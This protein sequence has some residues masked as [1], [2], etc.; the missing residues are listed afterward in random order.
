MEQGVGA[1]LAGAR[2]RRG[3]DLDRVEADTKIRVRYLRAIE[4]EEWDALPGDAYARAF[5]RTYAGYLGLDAEQLVEEQRR[6]HG[7]PRPGE[8]LP[9]VDPRPPRRPRRDLG[10]RV[11][12]R[13]LA[14]VVS[15]ALVVVLV[16]IGLLGGGGSGG[17]RGSAGGKRAGRS[18]SGHSKAAHAPSR[19][20]QESGHTL[21]LVADAEVWVCL[22][23]DGGEALVDGRILSPG[24]AEGPFRSGSFTFSLG[25]GEVTMT[26]D[27]K[28]AQIPPTSSPVGYSVTDGRLQQLSEGER[29]TCT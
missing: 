10:V 27:G 22:L 12:P 25:N 6:R 3:L 15:V 23:G 24:A 19:R 16:A 8:K 21:R 14:A 2:G 7:A 11:S 17:D 20:S 28:Q 13:L 5:L 29:P 1:K 9:Q 4:E 26:V 18:Q